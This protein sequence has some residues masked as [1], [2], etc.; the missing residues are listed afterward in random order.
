MLRDVSGKK[1]I[2]GSILCLQTDNKYLFSRGCRFLCSHTYFR[3][4][5]GFLRFNIYVVFLWVVTSCYCVLCGYRRF[6]EPYCIYLQDW[7]RRFHHDSIVQQVIILII[8]IDAKTSKP[9]IFQFLGSFAR[10]RK[11]TF[12]F[13][14]SVRPSV[15]LLG[16]NRLLLVGFL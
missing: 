11:S 8:S 14:M 5:S 7:R 10:L 4:N 12:S 9:F 6:G 3:E 13:V 15:C 2:K 16:T 1:N